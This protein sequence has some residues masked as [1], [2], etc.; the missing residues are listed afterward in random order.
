MA[1]T[2]NTK[3]VG[4]AY[5]DPSLDCLTVNGDSSLAGSTAIANATITNSVTSGYSYIRGKQ[6][7]KSQVTAMTTTAT[8]S[9]QAIAGGIISANPGGAA[10]ATYTMPTGT[11][12]SSGGPT[13]IVG[14]SV[15][16]SIVNIST[17]AAEDVTVVGDTG[18]TAKGNMFV[19]SNAA[20]S[21]NSSATFCIVCTGPSTFDF[22]RVG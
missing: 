4:V 1:I 15:T 5:S 11:V 16:F 13:L 18:M 3:A 17:N 22:Y 6:L 12:F 10:P 14:D 20:T 7:Y 2:T 8:I 19:P 9:P 21:D